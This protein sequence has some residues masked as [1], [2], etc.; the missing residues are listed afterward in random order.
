MSDRHSHFVR[1]RRLKSSAG[2]RERERRHEEVEMGKKSPFEIGKKVSILLLTDGR[3]RPPARNWT[4]SAAVDTA[5]KRK[6]LQ[7][8][9]GAT[10]PVFLQEGE[11][12]MRSHGNSSSPSL[13]LAGKQVSCPSL[14]LLVSALRARS[15]ALL[16]KRI[17]DR[18]RRRSF[19]SKFPEWSSIF[20]S[21]LAWEPRSWHNNPC[22]DNGDNFSEQI[23]SPRLKRTSSGRKRVSVR[24]A[25]WRRRR[26]VPA[27]EAGSSEVQRGK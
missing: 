15:R 24:G 22:R 2:K 16:A 26:E 20:L 13:P 23:P 5:L 6:F 25:R 14:V 1:D 27:L 9:R 19:I 18:G 12:E 11:R 3:Q 7:H 8:K 10:I 21:L 17:S 4:Q